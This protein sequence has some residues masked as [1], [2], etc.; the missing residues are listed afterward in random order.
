MDPST[1]EILAMVNKP[2]LRFERSAAETMWKRSRRRCA[3]ACVTDAYEPGSTFKIHYFGGG[4]GQRAWS[5]PT[6]GFYCSGSTLCGRRSAIECWGKPHGAESI[7]AGAAKF[8]QSGVRG[9]G[10]AA[11]HGS[12]LSIISNA[13]GLGKSHRIPACSGRGERHI[14][15]CNRGS[16]A[17]IS[18][19]SASGRA[20]RLRRCN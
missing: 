8:L 13:F 1:G 2:D 3:I 11:G 5:R 7:R 17:W 15:F 19:A 18:R 10:A 9:N 6:E 4:A 14:D 12:V 20:W 16:S